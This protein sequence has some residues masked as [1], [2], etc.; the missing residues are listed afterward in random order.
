M[1]V[2]SRPDQLAVFRATSSRVDHR[3]LG[4]IAGQPDEFARGVKVDE[5]APSITI[6][7]SLWFS[8]ILGPPTGQTWHL[9]W[10]VTSSSP[11]AQAAGPRRLAGEK[12]GAPSGR[13]WSSPGR[14]GR[15]RVLRRPARRPQSR[16]GVTNQTQS[17]W[18]QRPISAVQRGGRRQRA[19]GGACYT[20]ARPGMRGFAWREQATRVRV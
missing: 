14:A 6:R 20:P 17:R 2:P 1:A 9:L 5:P 15:G 3:D 10:T 12:R 7:C 16:R 18:R 4:R 11:P 13:P 8:A 19:G